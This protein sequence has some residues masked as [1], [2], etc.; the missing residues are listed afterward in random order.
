MVL[1][2][3]ACPNGSTGNN[4]ARNEIVDEDTKSTTT[5]RKPQKFPI[6]SDMRLRQPKE[7]LTRAAAGKLWKPAVSL[8]SGNI[9]VELACKKKAP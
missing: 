3:V 6:V 5:R 2:K 4:E 1:R 7:D 9:K 8:V